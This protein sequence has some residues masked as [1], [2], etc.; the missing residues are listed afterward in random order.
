MPTFAALAGIAPPQPVDG[1]SLVPTLTGEGQ[2]QH[3]RYLYF[4]LRGKDLII[5]NK[6]ET[7]SVEEIRKEAK[8]EVVVT[9]FASQP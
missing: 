7:R 8:T 2:Q 9:E 3:H 1:L 6:G 5:R 4:F